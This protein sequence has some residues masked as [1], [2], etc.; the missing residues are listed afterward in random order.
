MN[1]EK[2]RVLPRRW[3]LH[4]ILGEER[5]TARANGLRLQAT[6]STAMISIGGECIGCLSFVPRRSV[7]VSGYDS[8]AAA[9]RAVE[10]AAIGA[11]LA[12]R[13]T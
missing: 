9:I 13:S 7:S 1:C 5:W 8:R 3:S 6:R 2:K 11:G 12:R 4:K 10:G